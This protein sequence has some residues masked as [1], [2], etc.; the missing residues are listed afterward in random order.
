[1]GK[2][3]DKLST[4]SSTIIN[5]SASLQNKQIRSSAKNKIQNQNNASA[6]AKCKS[7]IQNNTGAKSSKISNSN[8]KNTTLESKTSKS[9]N[10]DK[11]APTN[12]SKTAKSDKVEEVNLVAPLDKNTIYLD[13]NGSKFNAL[14]DSGASVCCIDKKSIDK[15]NKNNQFQITPSHLVRITGVGGEEHPILG[16]ISLPLKIKGVLVEQTFIV[17][18]RLHCPVILGID[19]MQKHKV[20]IDFH[21]KIITMLDDYVAV[22][23]TCNDKIGYVR[24]LKPETLPPQSETVIKVRV[25]QQHK[26]QIVLLEPSHNLYNLELAGARCLVETKN[27]ITQY[28]L[29]NPTKKSITVYPSRVLANVDLID[30]KDISS[31]DEV[32]NKNSANVSNVNQSAETTAR[33]PNQ[34]QT[35]KDIQFNISNKNLSENQKQ[36]L[37][38]FLNKNK[39]VFATST[40]EIGKTDVYTHKIETEPGA[41]PVRMNYYRQDPIKKAEIERQTNE[42]LETGLI[43]RSTSFWNSPVVLVKKKDSSWRFAVDYRKL[44][45]VTIPMSQPIPRLDDVFDA[46]GESGA[47]MFSTLDLNSAFF[48]IGLDPESKKKSA[49]VTHEG[50]FEFNRMSF[51]L[52][53]ASFSFQLLM[54]Q[55]LKGLNWKFVLCYIDDI[56]VYSPDFNTHLQHLNQVFDRLREANLTLKPSKCTFGVD[57]V[58]F[59]GHVLSEGGVSVDTAKTDLVKD[60]PIPTTQKQ[61]RGFL[62]LCNY[63]RR[64][65]QDYAKIASPLNSLLKKEIGKNFSK[66]DWTDK[67]QIAFDTLKDN[68]ISA[69][70]LRFPDMSRPF[71]LSTDASGFSLGYI[72]GQVD[73]NGQEYVICY[74]GRAI[75]KEELKWNT[76]EKECLAIIEG[77]NSYKHYLT[78]KPFT[79]Y[80]DHANLEWLHNKKDPSGR[81][82]RWALKLQGYNYVIKHRK[83]IKNQNAD[84]LSRI[85]YEQMFQM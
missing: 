51:G 76:T 9:Q 79:I 18:E 15:I 67:C 59:L 6:E 60:F 37:L 71:I 48:Q 20:R 7:K 46:L 14:I 17:L 68:L 33:V 26:N 63:Y 35:N 5:K 81:L 65:V 40:A 3:H 74:G 29:I 75:R 53:N 19:F 64:F 13:I 34:S 32:S 62:G 66:V 36:T 11:N 72:L 69:P 41:K 31:Y 8:L 42:M 50:V 30:Q 44:N 57:K 12:H 23:L 16:N 43:E 54:S 24:C 52:R 22:A 47:T 21:H 80:T 45:Q 25:S 28:R 78:H 10:Y 82:G 4:G 38:N 83:G 70:I 2:M 55:V 85:V 61:L 27:R 56:L 73:K 1:M 49:F 84:A 39:D 77:I 58:N